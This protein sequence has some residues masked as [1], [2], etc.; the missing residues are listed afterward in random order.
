MPSHILEDETQ[1]F[2]SDILNF[3][4]IKN[5]TSFSSS[6]YRPVTQWGCVYPDITFVNLTQKMMI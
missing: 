4:K 5:I 6:I 1:F 3:S 2:K